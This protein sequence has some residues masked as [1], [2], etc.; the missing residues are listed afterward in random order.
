MNTGNAL[1]EEE[2]DEM[3]REVDIDGD[4]LINYYELVKILITK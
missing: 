1:S 3:A 4:G 2:A